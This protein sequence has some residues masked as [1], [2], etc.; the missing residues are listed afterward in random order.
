MARPPGQ[1]TKF[2]QELADKIC[3]G[4]STSSRGIRFVCK[5]L[6]ITV[7]SV[8]HWLA[9]KP[10]F[11]QQYAKAREAQSQLLFDEI[12]SIADSTEEGETIRETTNVEGETT[13]EVRRTDM[14]EHRK[15]R[16]D[17]R[18]WHLSKLLPKKYG[19]RLDVSGALTLD[20]L[21]AAVAN[22]KAKIEGK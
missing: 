7:E 6:D 15:L 4:I 11:F 22:A 2:T 14:T 12:T 16:I 19:E 8:Y 9:K 21:E 20:G 1:P 13:T 5:D 18:K 3:F 17:A 10:E